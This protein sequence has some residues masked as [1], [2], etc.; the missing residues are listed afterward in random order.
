M[1]LMDHLLPGSH[2]R[3]LGDGVIV[4]PLR[5][6]D[7]SEWRELRAG[8]HSHLEPWE[9]SSWITDLSFLPFH[10]GL[11]GQ[12]RDRWM[13]REYALAVCRSYDGALTGGIT[14]YNFSRLPSGSAFIGYWCGPAYVRPGLTRAAIYATCAY[15]FEV[16][17]LGRL[18]AACIADNEPSVSLLE[19]VG[20]V[21]E[22]V[23]KD[24]LNIN[25]V[26]RDHDLFG[27]ESPRYARGETN[28]GSL[29]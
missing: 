1:A 5:S 21:R 10:R 16:L 28:R 18:S 3:I 13:R 19:Q 7:F 12:A 9:P 24:Y 29:A 17:K 15:A 14:L 22:G 2:I 27:L 25:G 4:R 11:L 6:S 20:F 26:S 23:A 8:S